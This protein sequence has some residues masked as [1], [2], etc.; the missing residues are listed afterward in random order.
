V[1]ASFHPFSCST[2]APKQFC[3]VAP[4]PKPSE[5]GHGMRSLPSAASRP[6]RQWKP[7]LATRVTTADNRVRVQTVLPQPSRSRFQTCWFLRLL[8]HKLVP[9]PFSFPVRRLLHARTG[10]TFTASRRGTRPINGHCPR[11]W[12]YD[13]FSFQPRPELR[14]SPVESCLRPWRWSNQSGVL[15]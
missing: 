5:S 8:R 15:K 10:G 6:V 11:G 3:A 7:R 2:T 1:A 4:A 14:G 9:E 12:T 13:L